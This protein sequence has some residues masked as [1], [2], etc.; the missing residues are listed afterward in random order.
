[1]QTHLRCALYARLPTACASSMGV[2]IAGGRSGTLGVFWGENFFG[3]GIWRDVNEMPGEAQVQ[4]QAV[5]GG[6]KLH[7]WT[8]AGVVHGVVMAGTEWSS[9]GSLWCPSRGSRMVREKGAK[10]VHTRRSM[11]RKLLPR[12]S[13]PPL[14]PLPV[15]VRTTAP[16]LAHRVPYTYPMGHILRLSSKHQSHK[17]PPIIHS[18]D[19]NQY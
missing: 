7:A 10:V 14:P 17:F 5:E 16:S 1:M 2:M 13:L 4:K 3:G 6:Q 15:F 18:P 8:H 19:A 12:M 11:S 9:G